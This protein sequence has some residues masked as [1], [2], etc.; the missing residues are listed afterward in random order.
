MLYNLLVLLVYPWNFN[1]TMDIVCTRLLLLCLLT[2]VAFVGHVL[3]CIRASQNPWKACRIC[4]WIIVFFVSCGMTIAQLIEGIHLPQENA[5]ARAVVVATVL[6]TWMPCYQFGISCVLFFF[7]C[8]QFPTHA[9]E[10]LQQLP[11]T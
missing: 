5:I 1:H 4:S 8:K 7:Y 9:T 11:R 2:N 10:H 3:T 6:S